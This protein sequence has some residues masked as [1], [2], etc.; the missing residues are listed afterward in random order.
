MSAALC[1]VVDHARG[2]RSRPTDPDD[3]ERTGLPSDDE[4][5]P[6]EQDDDDDARLPNDGLAERCVD[7]QQ[8][9]PDCQQLG[10]AEFL[11][12]LLLLP[13]VLEYLQAQLLGPVLRG[14]APLGLALAS[15]RGRA[16]LPLA[17]VLEPVVVRGVGWLVGVLEKGPPLLL[18]DPG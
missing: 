7:G 4:E 6:P 12:L 5:G 1:E 8:E 3:A 17:Q 10:Q 16:R 13:S 11:G 18:L 15:T 2:V 9:Q 14:L